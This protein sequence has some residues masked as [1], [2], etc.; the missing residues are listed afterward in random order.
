M[1]HDSSPNSAFVSFRS[2]PLKQQGAITNEDLPD[3][4]RIELPVSLSRPLVV[5]GRCS[6][7]GAFYNDGLTIADGGLTDK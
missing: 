3:G 6:C 7:V 5:R 2:A 1:D 4:R